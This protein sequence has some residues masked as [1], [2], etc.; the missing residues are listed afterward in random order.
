MKGLLSDGILPGMLRDVYVNRRSGRLGFV[1]GKEQYTIRFAGGHILYCESSSA[2]GQLGKLMVAKGVIPEKVRLQADETVRRT[3][4][5]MGEVLVGMRAIDTGALED[6]LAMQVR[7]LLL[8]V[9]A[10][11]DGACG[12]LEEAAPQESPVTLK[13][14][15]AEM[16]MEAVRL[17]RN[18]AA[19]RAD[20]GDLDRVVILSTDPLLRYQRVTLSPTD[21]FVLSRVDG[22]ATAQQVL[23]L[24]PMPP[25]DVERSLFGLLCIG[26]V[27]YLP[28]E[29]EVRASS[30]DQRRA[31]ILAAYEGLAARDHFEVLGISRDATQAEVAAAFHRRAHRFHPDAHHD[32]AL[33]DLHDRLQAIFTR[34]ALAW[35]TLRTPALRHEYVSTLERALRTA[36]G[37][38]TAE[39]RDSPEEAARKAEA[40][41][42]MAEAR[43]KDGRQWEAIGLLE[44]L[45]T[46][47]GGG[48]RR[49]A[50]LMLADLYARNPRAGKSVE[51]QL[52]AV[53]DENPD[54]VDA[55]VRLAR[56]YRDRQMTARAI[57]Q[58]QKAL[59]LQ[60]GHR[61]A[62]ELLAALDAQAGKG[63]LGRLFKSG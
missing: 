6:A 4:Q 16:I 62:Q 54:F 59:E 40:A 57:E 7:E 31:E 36:A 19:I 28:A 44:G 24:V 33:A 46:V 13:L 43:A 15:T 29:T 5:R 55:R 41:M 11:T 3:G 60:P 45:V 32:P 47:T 52:I 18:A 35:E 49:R 37:P 53:I 10:W 22:L 25:E 56:L 17:S 12:F 63:L 48:L 2:D 50:R 27:E 58:A 42:A 61:A 9:F 21:G 34:V 14:S 26:M 8:R 51:E 20:L 1:R 30:A 39:A 23:Q 38:A